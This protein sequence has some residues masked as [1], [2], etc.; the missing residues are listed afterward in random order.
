MHVFCI[1]RETFAMQQ[2]SGTSQG[3]TRLWKSRNPTVSVGYTLSTM[4]YLTSTNGN[5]RRTTCMCGFEQEENHNSVLDTTLRSRPD[6]QISVMS[7]YEL[8]CSKLGLSLS[9]PGDHAFRFMLLKHAWAANA[10]PKLSLWPVRRFGR[11]HLSFYCR[12]FT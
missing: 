4:W 7:R 10:A 8:H 2:G 11:L 1:I 12:G 9:F 6:E 3:E 5:V